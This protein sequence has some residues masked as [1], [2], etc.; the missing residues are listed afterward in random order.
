M[1]IYRR[2]SDRLR[3]CCHSRLRVLQ[4]TALSHRAAGVQAH[5][6]GGAKLSRGTISVQRQLCVIVRVCLMPERPADR[7]RG[8]PEHAPK[9][10]ASS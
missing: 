1:R 3:V 7:G 5:L 4:P 6:R 8:I 10:A 9:Y 2:C